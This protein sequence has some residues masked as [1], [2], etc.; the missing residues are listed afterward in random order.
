MFFLTSLYEYYNVQQYRAQIIIKFTYFYYRED[1][2]KTTTLI[3]FQINGNSFL[4]L[5]V[6]KKLKVKLKVNY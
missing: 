5:K 4:L 3:I 2:K 6:R 1:F